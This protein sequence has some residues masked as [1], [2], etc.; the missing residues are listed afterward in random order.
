MDFSLAKILELTNR[1]KNIL[2]LLTYAY[3]AL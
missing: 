3:V 2:I 1:T